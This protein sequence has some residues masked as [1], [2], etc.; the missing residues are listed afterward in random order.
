MSA[1][2]ARTTYHHGD[3][4]DALVAAGLEATRAGGPDALALRALTR[5]AGVSPNAAYRHFADRRALLVAVAGECQELL[6]E[7]MRA[8]IRAEEVG[9]DG[10]PDRAVARLRGVGLG[11]IDFAR[12]ER[13]WFATAFLSFDDDSDDASAAASA[14]RLDD[15]VPPPFLL[16]TQALDHLVDV[17]VLAPDR[18]RGAEWPCWSA[19]H[20]FADLVTRGPLAAH[21]APV[22]D[23]LAARVVDDI[24]RGVLT[25]PDP[26]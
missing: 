24:I 7:A 20:G 17:G 12:A 16:L 10:E 14:V 11:Y 13:G 22:A 25:T 15:R 1:A 9:W 26:A 6:G 3:L 2:D 18:R 5:A 19:V 8:R 23:A 21:P 4:R